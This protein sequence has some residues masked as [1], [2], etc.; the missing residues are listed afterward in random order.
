MFVSNEERPSQLQNKPRE[1]THHHGGIATHACTRGNQP[2]DPAR[3]T[4]ADGLRQEGR[5]CCVPCL[6]TACAV[7]T[8]RL[9]RRIRSG[10]ARTPAGIVTWSVRRARSPKQ[11][12]RLDPG[13]PSR[14]VGLG[15]HCPHQ[16]S[17]EAFLLQTTFRVRSSVVPVSP[18]TRKGKAGAR[19]LLVRQLST[20]VKVDFP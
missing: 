8:L 6:A 5:G 12:G 10:K 16:P 18:P 9:A 13:L 17:F 1:Q 14:H 7:Y 11:A 4:E 20:A 3:T 15:R 19:S 2:V